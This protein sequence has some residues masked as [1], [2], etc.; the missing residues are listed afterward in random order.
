MT[1]EKAF[2]LVSEICPQ[3]A[4]LLW[5][6]TNHIGCDTAWAVADQ[7]GGDMIEE[8]DARA[9]LEIIAAGEIPSEW[10]AHSVEVA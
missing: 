1:H 5:N 8:N 9:A 3:H 10:E 6:T 4:G 7:F 2:A